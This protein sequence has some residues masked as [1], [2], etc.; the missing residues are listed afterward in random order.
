MVAMAG[1]IGW[2]AARISP[3][4][5]VHETTQQAPVTVRV[6]PVIIEPLSASTSLTA[7]VTPLNTVTVVSRVPGT[8]EW[9]IGDVGTVVKKGDVVARIDDTDMQ[10]HLRQAQA[11]YDQAVAALDRLRAGASV[12][13]RR[14]VEATVSQAQIAFN[15]AE[16][17]FER[18]QFLFDA[19]VIAKDAFDSAR[20]QYD[21]A[22]SQ[23]EAARQMLAQVER[24]ASQEEL[25]AAQ[26]QVAQAQV[27]LEMAE[28]QVHDAQI[29]ASIDGRIA[30]KHAQVGALVG[31]G[32]PIV[33]LVYLDDVVVEVGVSDRLVNTVK[34]SDRVT[35]HIPAIPG[36][37]YEG[38]VLAVAPVVDQYTRLY[39]V[40]ILVSNPDHQIKPGMMA[41]VEIVTDR[42]DAATT[43]P[44]SAIV[45]KS[46]GPVI[47]LVDASGTVEER[48]VSVGIATDGRVQVEPVTQGELV[49]ISR[50]SFLADGVRVN[51]E[52]EGL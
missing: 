52:R 48:P 23:L 11:V 15:L 6:A 27:A 1:T 34:P 19:G 8:V 25:R 32:S 49:V 4:D 18:A 3:K 43:L 29:A 14:Q 50:Q 9:M 21:L 26:A 44:A 42:A 7:T 37:V 51:I 45:H 22:S 46:T 24:G 16:E 35:V 31:A 47:Y 28:K 38:E 36:A 12:E 20:S 40:R 13:E 41:T 39:P 30:V 17:G 2:M 10:L 33:T 5:P